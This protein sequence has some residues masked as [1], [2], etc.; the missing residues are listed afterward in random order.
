MIQKD[1]RTMQE[2]T[3]DHAREQRG[4]RRNYIALCAVSTVVLAAKVQ[5]QGPT[6]GYRIEE[7][8]HPPIALPECADS[9]FLVSGSRGRC[10]ESA[11]RSTSPGRLW[12]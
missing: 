1:A 5:H 9:E 6:V 2:P 4:A 8:G 12:R 10:C 11:S 7:A 3:I